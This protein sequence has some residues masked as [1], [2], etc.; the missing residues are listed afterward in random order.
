MSSLLVDERVYLII[1]ITH[2]FPADIISYAGFIRLYTNSLVSGVP[3]NNYTSYTT[4][5]EAQVYYTLNRHTRR[6]VRMSEQ[7]EAMFGSEEEATD[8]NW[9]GY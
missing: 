9:R 3:G 5:N 7:D 1:G 2:H 6:V 4:Y 8:V